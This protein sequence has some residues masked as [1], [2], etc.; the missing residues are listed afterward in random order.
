MNCIHV[1]VLQQ[2]AEARSF[3]NV[4]R[5]FLFLRVKS[6]SSLISLKRDTLWWWFVVDKIRATYTE[7]VSVSILFC[8]KVRRHISGIRRTYIKTSFRTD[9]RVQLY[10]IQ[11]PCEQ[12]FV[13][14]HPLLC[15]VFP[16]ARVI[17]IRC[18]WIPTYLLHTSTYVRLRT[19]SIIQLSSY[20]YVQLSYSYFV[21][22]RF[23]VYFIDRKVCGILRT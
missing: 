14:K 15:G 22:R 3:A 1:K 16:I 7:P 4:L 13:F 12:L 8:R 23:Y 9:N 5:T 11:L 21:S 6:Y 10:V 17:T 19:F 2:K 20:M 18:A